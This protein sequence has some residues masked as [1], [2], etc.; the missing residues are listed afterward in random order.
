[1]QRENKMHREQAGG[2]LREFLSA[3]ARAAVVSGET[4]S[5]KTT[6]VR[7]TLD[8]SC[9]RYIMLTS[10]NTV[11]AVIEN[12]FNKESFSQYDVIALDNAEDWVKKPVTS[13]YIIEKIAEMQDKKFII[14]G[15]GIEKCL[16]K[17]E[18]AVTEA[19]FVELIKD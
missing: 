11:E 10:E 1:M 9:K 6:L 15:I 8:E 17:L 16:K 12:T 7:K 19:Y 14:I 5:G 3:D 13:E 2:I 4:F 18:K